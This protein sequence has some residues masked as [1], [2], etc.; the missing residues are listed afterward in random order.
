MSIL[1][2]RRR[3]LNVSAKHQ[4]SDFQVKR[5]ADISVNSFGWISLEI[6]FCFNSFN[7]QDNL[8]LWLH[9]T[10][11]RDP[12]QTCCRCVG[13][14]SGSAEMSGPAILCWTTDN[15]LQLLISAGIL[16]FGWGAHSRVSRHNCSVCL[17]AAQFL[18]PHYVR[19]AGQQ[20][21]LQGKQVDS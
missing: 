4:V 20:S 17:L 15:M 1:V 19:R 3:D 8:S 7:H 6:N 5:H 14:L 9:V 12:L 11:V 13:Y 21:S 16:S 18:E 2:L 10:A